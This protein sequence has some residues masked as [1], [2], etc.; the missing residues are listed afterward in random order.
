[1]FERQH[2]QP[3]VFD[4]ISSLCQWKIFVV[5][6]PYGV[7]TGAGL[8][9]LV[10]GSVVFA[11][12]TILFWGALCFA[13]STLLFLPTCALVA[14]RIHRV[15]VTACE[16]GGAMCLR[17]GFDLRAL[18]ELGT[19]PECGTRYELKNNLAAWQRSELWASKFRKWPWSSAPP[20]PRAVS[21]MKA[22]R[23]G[24]KATDGRLPSPPET[25]GGY[26]LANPVKSD[27]P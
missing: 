10:I 7:I 20:R 12:E 2:E 11:N 18:P 16:R 1:M 3:I 23:P 8:I 19:C 22:A 14:S 4:Q 21:D 24:V 6:I 9:L 5:A 25:Q 27:R 26:S 17:C 13:F 15:C